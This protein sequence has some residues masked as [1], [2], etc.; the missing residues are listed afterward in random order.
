MLAVSCD[1]GT[2]GG[3]RAV[4]RDRETVRGMR[5]SAPVPDPAVEACAYAAVAAHLRGSFSDI[6]LV[7]EDTFDTH[8]VEVV[9]DA[10]LA[11]CVEQLGTLANAVQEQPA[12]LAQLLLAE[13][14][15][16]QDDDLLPRLLAAVGAQIRGDY[17]TRALLL[18]PGG[19]PKTLVKAGVA[20]L[21]AVMAWVAGAVGGD[22]AEQ[23]AA[24]CLALSRR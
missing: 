20:T 4:R 10:V 3:W 19:D 8:P 15:D 24:T 14:S 13:A 5:A 16:A 21:A 11:A 2:G 9:L 6:G 7:L 12:D 23:A 18:D 1:T 17:D 22:P